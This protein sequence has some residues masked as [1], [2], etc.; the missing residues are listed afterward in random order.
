MKNF[1]IDRLREAIQT[2]ERAMQANL[3]T[4]LY[5][6]NW[7][8][9]SNPRPSFYKRAIQHLRIKIANSISNLADTIRGYSNDY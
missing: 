4:Q 5:G 2:T 6:D 7:D 3:N 8:A 1:Q 9:V